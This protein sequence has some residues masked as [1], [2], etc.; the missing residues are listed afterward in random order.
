MAAFTAALATVGRALV[1][2][3]SESVYVHLAAGCLL[4]LVAGHLPFVGGLITLGLALIG[5]GTLVA[6]RFGGLWPGKNGPNSGPYR[7]TVDG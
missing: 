6:T 1:K 7:T 3:K 2:H 5:V 4:Y